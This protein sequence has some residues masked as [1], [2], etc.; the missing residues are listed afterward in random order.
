VRR[1]RNAGWWVIFGLFA[2]LVVLA[3]IGESEPD[4]AGPREA[5]CPQGAVLRHARLLER[6]QALYVK[7][8]AEGE[9]CDPEQGEAQPPLVETEAQI[10]AAERS[11]RIAAASSSAKRFEAATRSYVNALVTYPFNGAARLG[12]AEVLADPEA[13]VVLTPAG[14][15]SLGSKLIGAGV[16]GQAEAAILAG[17][18]D[19][20]ASG[21][22]LRRASQDASPLGCRKKLAALNAR[23]AEAVAALNSATLR[24]HEGKIAAARERYADALAANAE[25]TEAR[26]ELEGSIEEESRFDAI[27]SWLDGV[28]ATLKNALSWVVPLAIGLL[29]LALLVWIVVREGSARIIWMRCLF[30]WIGKRSAFFHDAAVPEIKIE[31]FEG[32]DSTKETGKELATLLA[33]AIA[34]ESRRGGSFPFDRIN[35]GSSEDSKFTTVVAEALSETSETKLLGELIKVLSRLFRRRSIV[36]TGRLVSARDQGVGL[37]LEMEANGRESG[38]EVTLW[39]KTF[40]PQPEGEEGVRY[41]RLVAAAKVWARQHLAIAY[42]LPRQAKEASWLPDALF[43]SGVTWQARRDFERAE[44][45]YVLALEKDPDLLS[46][47]HNLATIEMHCKD[48][49]PAEARLRKLRARLS[50][51][52]DERAGAAGG[53]GVKQAKLRPMLGTASLYSLILAIV[54]PEVDSGAEPN[55]RLGE[56]LELS[57]QLIRELIELI[58]GPDN[59]FLG[60]ENVQELKAAELPSIVVR[61]SLLVRQFPGRRAR[62]VS[63]A[64]A[65]QPLIAIERKELDRRLSELEPWQLIDY[66]QSREIVSRRTHYNLACYYT[67]LGTHARGSDRARCFDLA[68]KELKTSLVGGELGQWADLDPSLAPLK[69]ALGSEAFAKALQAHAIKKLDDQGKGKDDSGKEKDKEEEPKP[70]EP[71]SVAKPKG[72]IVGWLGEGLKRLGELLATSD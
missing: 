18:K 64:L 36:L 56:T 71:V 32:S 17:L 46:A 47:A 26:T 8:A 39:E 3:M 2:L 37:M 61:A 41:L 11:V 60:S 59:E 65:T 10:G 40:D 53:D 68:L 62:A 66:V 70:P 13:E 45:L 14:Y 19:G 20:A 24:A 67:T 23:S 50:Q 44:A 49:A 51:L 4:L 16:L 58:D 29:L 7:A 38:A 55:P 52:R 69:Q 12:F 33:A 9:A 1:G 54:Y 48:F 63:E 27:G 25:L 21:G 30:E 22:A 35:K 34:A 6:A 28:P 5:L 42:E 72:G 57:E 15:C 31:P 43:Q